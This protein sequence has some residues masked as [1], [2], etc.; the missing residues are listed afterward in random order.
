MGT[1]SVRKL[2]SKRNFHWSY[3]VVVELR[4]NLLSSVRYAHHY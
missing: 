4:A 3:T 2:S 1:K